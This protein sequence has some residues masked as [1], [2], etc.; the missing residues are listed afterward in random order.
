MYTGT[1]DT[2]GLLNDV[3]IFDSFPLFLCDGM[4]EQCVG[5]VHHCEVL[6]RPGRGR[7]FFGACSS[8]RYTVQCIF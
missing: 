5:S 3:D 7:P 1:V 2:V 6:D 4:S 8:H